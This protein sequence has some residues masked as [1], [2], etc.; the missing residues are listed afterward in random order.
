[1][2]E[3]LVIFAVCLLWAV[4]GI[5]VVVL[6]GKFMPGVHSHLDAWAERSPKLSALVLCGPL[7][8]IGVAVVD[9]VYN[10]MQGE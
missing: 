5:A 6:T 3:V 7:A 4:L 8:A 10:G 9:F 1:M 2:I